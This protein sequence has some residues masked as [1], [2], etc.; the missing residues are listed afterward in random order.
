LSALGNDLSDKS[1]IKDHISLFNLPNQEMSL[2][3]VEKKLIPKHRRCKTT[4]T[5]V[6]TLDLLSDGSRN[7]E[8]STSTG[9]RLSLGMNFSFNVVKDVR[10]VKWKKEAPW[11]REISDGFSWVCYCRNEGRS[12]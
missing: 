10:K 5:N 1:K 4:S 9:E 12:C 7:L 2:V 3:A 6:P 11:Y 8:S